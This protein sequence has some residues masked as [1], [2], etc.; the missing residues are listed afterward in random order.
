MTKMQNLWTGP[1]RPQHLVFQRV[2]HG[3]RTSATRIGLIAGVLIGIE[4]TASRNTALP[5]VPAPVLAAWASEQALALK[6]PRCPIAKRQE[7]PKSLSP[8]EE[9]LL[10]C[11]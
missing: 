1:R 4:T 7:Q 2:N 9:T 5:I 8:S 6:K 10:V 3:R 11:H